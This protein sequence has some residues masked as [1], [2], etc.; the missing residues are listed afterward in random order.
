MKRRLP[1]VI[2]GVF[3]LLILCFIWGQSMMPRD[4]S[5]GES[6]SL[7]QLLKPIFDPAGKIEDGIFHHYL[8]K[9]A[10]F[11]EY[12]AFGFCVSGFFGNLNLKRNARRTV[13]AFL[14]SAAVAAVDESLQIFSPD[15][16]PQFRDVLLDC[17]GALFGILVF[18]LFFHVLFLIRKRAKT[19]RASD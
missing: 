3:T 4:V 1:A 7:M 10:H 11:C 14:S 16:G 19:S 12:A 2:F 17:C 5:A 18:L 13:Y 8:R 6:E 9:A 15:R